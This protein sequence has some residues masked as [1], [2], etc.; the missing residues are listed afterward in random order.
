MW[1]E[2]ESYKI[3][4]NEIRASFFESKRGSRHLHNKDKILAKDVHNNEITSL[5]IICWGSNWE[6]SSEIRRVIR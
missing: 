6:K 4:H 2:G 1:R 5:L 3:F